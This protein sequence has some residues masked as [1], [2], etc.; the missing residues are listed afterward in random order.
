MRKLFLLA[1]AFFSTL[2]FAQDR[3]KLLER[4]SKQKDDTAK[5]NMY[6]KLAN[7]YESIDYGRAMQNADRMLRLG[8]KLN[9]VKGIQSAYGS[10]ARIFLLMEKPDSA[11]YFFRKQLNNPFFKDK[12]KVTKAYSNIALAWQ[13]KQQFD[14]AFAY[15]D[16]AI[17]MSKLSR[18]KNYLCVILNNMGL[19]VHAMGNPE[20]SLDYFQQAYDCM[21]ENRDTEH[22]P[23]VVNNLASLYAASKKTNSDA[24]FLRLLKDSH[25]IADEN[26]KATVFLNLAHFYSSEGN[27]DKSEVFFHRADSVFKRMKAPENPEIL[28]GLGKVALARGKFI[29]AISDFE[30]IKKRFPDYIQ[31]EMLLHDLAQAYHESHQPEKA[32]AIYEELL[33]MKEQKRSLEVQQAIT[34]AQE[35]INFISKESEIQQLK[36]EKDVLSANQLRNLA[37]GIALFVLIS[38]GSWFYIRKER[39]KRQI[40]ELL[41]DQKNRKIAEFA[42]KL[43]YR[44]KLIADIEAKFET[45]KEEQNVQD[46]KSDIIDNLDLTGDGETFSHYFEDQHKGFYAALKKIAPDLTNNDL[47]LCSLTKLRL[48]LKETANVLNLSVDAVKSGRYRIRKK[49]SLSLEDNLSDFLNTL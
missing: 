26:V 17:E 25:S 10:K 4:L 13:Q 36:L 1:F 27:L 5:V 28:H 31:T 39:A 14:S 37:I 44:N 41:L 35:N 47:R 20:K 18:S 22:L 46:L 21:I 19:T 33:A 40:N 9:Y 38:F 23:N 30:R 16:K 2:A 49:L 8:Q 12:D 43:E 45:F 11:L 24:M 7:A 15:F 6:G 3:T 42:E 48:S 34:K 32:R 29:Q